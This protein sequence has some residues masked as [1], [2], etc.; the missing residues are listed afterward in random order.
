[1]NLK[2]IQL[3]SGEKLILRRPMIEDAKRIIEY[4][5]IVGGE[6]NNLLF[7]KDEFHL[8][9]EEEKEHIKRMNNDSNS[10]MILGIIDDNIV[11]LAQIT[12][13][14]RKRIAHN[15]EVSISVKKDY[16]RNGIGSAVMEEIIRFAR[17]GSVIK[18]ISLGVR[19][20]NINA[21]KMY[22][23]LG[24]VKV[25]L[26]KNY[27]NINDNFDDEILMDLYI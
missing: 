7:G 9:V 12:S 13:S 22:E 4:V 8:T 23:E 25:G 15:S 10:L 11:S 6:S 18:N 1:M 16:W 19:A 21:I 3:K 5:N 20:S 17:E 14:N 24:F 27:F 2:E 26:H